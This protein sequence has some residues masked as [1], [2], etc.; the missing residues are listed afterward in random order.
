MRVVADT[1]AI[2]WY[3]TDPQRLSVA[4]LRALDETEGTEG[5]VVSSWTV[6]ELWMTEREDARVLLTGAQ[7]NGADLSGADL[8]GAYALPRTTGAPTWPVRHWNT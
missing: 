3:L 7:L 8:T 4:A 1:Q 5:I 2:Y 6:P